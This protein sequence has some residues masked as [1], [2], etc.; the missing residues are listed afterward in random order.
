MK[1]NLA[2]ACTTC[3][4]SLI[5]TSLVPS[6]SLAMS[7]KAP[8]QPAIVHT[9]VTSDVPSDAIWVGKSDQARSCG[10]VKGVD[11]DSMGSDLTSKGIKIL[12]RKKIP[13]GKVRI[14]M[15]GADKGDMNGY[16]IAKKD[17]EKAKELGFQILPGN[18]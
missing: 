2:L 15:C 10:E 13:D 5:G 9:N 1:N 3:L 4:V 14:Q 7:K 18:Y 16:L 17:L 11:I 12:T 6:Q 8:A